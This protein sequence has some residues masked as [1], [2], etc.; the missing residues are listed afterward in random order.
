MT[1]LY[2]KNEIPDL[3]TSSDF[4]SHLKSLSEN[5]RKLQVLSLSLS[6]ILSPPTPSTKCCLTLHFC[7]V[8]RP[9]CTPRFSPSPSLILAQLSRATCSS[10]RGGSYMHMSEWACIL[11]SACLPAGNMSINCQVLRYTNIICM[12]RDYFSWLGTLSYRVGC[13]MSRAAHRW[14]HRNISSKTRGR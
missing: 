7:S 13:G 5:S 9:L 12:W 11:T 8:S 1:S 3:Q 14:C 2:S 4:F 10:A 6:V